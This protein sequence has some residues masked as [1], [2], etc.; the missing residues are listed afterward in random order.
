MKNLQS[1]LLFNRACGNNHKIINFI[2]DRHCSNK[3]S[4]CY[5]KEL[6]IKFVSFDLSATD[7]LTKSDN[8]FSNNCKIIKCLQNLWDISPK[9]VAIEIVKKYDKNVDNMS[10]NG[11]FVRQ[12]LAIELVSWYRYIFACCDSDVWINAT[13]LITK[14]NKNLNFPFQDDLE[15]LVI[16][17]LPVNYTLTLD[18]NIDQQL[19]DFENNY[20]RLVIISENHLSITD[21]KSILKKYNNFPDFQQANGFLNLKCDVTNDKNLWTNR[22]TNPFIIEQNSILSFNYF[23]DNRQFNIPLYNVRSKII[24]IFKFK[25]VFDK[26]KMCLFK[27]RENSLG[28]PLKNILNPNLEFTET[29]YKASIEEFE[30]FFENHG[31]SEVSIDQ[32]YTKITECIT[33][34]NF[35]KG[36]FIILWTNRIIL[37]RNNIPTCPI[38][39]DNFQ[40]KSVDKKFLIQPI[41]S[42]DAYILLQSNKHAI[43]ILSN[44]PLTGDKERGFIMINHIQLRQRPLAFIPYGTFTSN[45]VNLIKKNKQLTLNIKL[46]LLKWLLQK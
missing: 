35:N 36:K 41:S 5:C 16:A 40:Y 17:I 34:F 10:I 39:I 15:K 9:E 45:D 3:P 7:T 43:L 23:D 26:S 42:Y 1:I 4:L 29:L 44:V 19:N 21:L 2:V 28:P 11:Y 22:I 37:T 46:M 31:L 33:Q 32:N 14:K 6:I 18:Y 20:Y 38:I 24:D 8:L 30:K 13:N 27:I 12:N 25:E